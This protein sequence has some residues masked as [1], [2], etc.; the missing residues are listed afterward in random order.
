MN[1]KP[2][3]AMLISSAD[4]V[5][6]ALNRLNVGTVI[7]LSTTKGKKQILLKQPIDCGHKFSIKNI[8]KGEPIIK[9]G[10]IIGLATEDIPEGYHVHIHNVESRRGR[11]DKKIL[12]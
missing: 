10:E 1:K 3:E 11:G 7:S 2:K 9:Y 12:D 6:T 5:A 4:N 8:N